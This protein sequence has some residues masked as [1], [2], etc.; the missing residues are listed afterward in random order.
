MIKVFDFYIDGKLRKSKLFSIL[1]DGTY[2]V[3]LEEP[4][5]EQNK[6]L[7]YGLVPDGS[8]GLFSRLN[9]KKQALF[10]DAIKTEKGWTTNLTLDEYVNGAFLQTK[11]TWT[12]N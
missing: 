12:L 1:E 3:M 9:D 11:K 7:I 8:V 5:T 2:I 4:L 6:S 10:Q